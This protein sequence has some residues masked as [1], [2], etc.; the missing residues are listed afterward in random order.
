MIQK[1]K[2]EFNKNGYNH[3]IHLRRGGLVIYELS[4]K[5]GIVDEL[6]K[7]RVRNPQTMKIQDKQGK[8]KITQ[9]PKREILAY[10]EDFGRNGFSF[11]KLSNAEKKMK[12]LEK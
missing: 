4:S 2:K 11:Q 12:E 8:Y 5:Y 3:K 1:I 9:L 10:N 6:H 7:I